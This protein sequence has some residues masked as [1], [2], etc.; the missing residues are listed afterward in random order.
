MKVN[1]SLRFPAAST[2][3]PRR[4]FVGAGVLLAATLVAC[5][6][7]APTQ[8]STTLAGDDAPGTSGLR[9]A[10]DPATGELTS[11]PVAADAVQSVTDPLQWSSEG[12]VIETLPDGT[13]RVDLQG[14]FQSAS[15]ARVAADGALEIRYDAEQA[16]PAKSGQEEAP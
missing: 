10:I 5:S 9:A 1:A 12:L 16:A 7:Q 11:E 15:Y 8:T 14:R 3:A 6:P 2:L 13:E 4:G